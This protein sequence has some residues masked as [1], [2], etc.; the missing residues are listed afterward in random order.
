M[1]THHEAI[2]TN[3]RRYPRIAVNLPIDISDGARFYQATVKNISRGGLLIDDIPN[4]INCNCMLRTVVSVGNNHFKLVCK[5]KHRKNNGSSVTLGTEID[6]TSCQWL[7]F[8]MNQEP[9]VEGDVWDS[10]R[11]FI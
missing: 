1:D 11:T 2:Q 6:D 5:T 8:V 10:V 7:A 3:K 4:R 9:P